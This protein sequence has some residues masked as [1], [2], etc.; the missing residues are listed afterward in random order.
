ML[1]GR[2]STPSSTSSLNSSSCAMAARARCLSSS[3]FAASLLIS[4]SFRCLRLSSFTSMDALHE[5]K[6]QCQQCFYSFKQRTFPASTA[7]N[8]GPMA[9]S[10][11]WGTGLVPSPALSP[12]ESLALRLVPFG[13]CSTSVS[14]RN[15]TS[16]ARAPTVS[17]H[18]RYFRNSIPVHK[19][20]KF[21]SCSIAYSAK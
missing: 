13:V 20:S 8:S 9:S 16:E 1:I 7:H 17:V 21:G 10:R 5:A 15:T 14:S 3:C 18:N 2:S 19:S 11:D 12:I 6:P 4:I